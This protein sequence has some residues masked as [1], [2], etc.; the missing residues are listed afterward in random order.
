MDEAVFSDEK[1]DAVTVGD[2]HC[3]R[4]V[5]DSFRREEDVDRLLLKGGISRIM[6][7]LDDMQLWSAFFVLIT[8]LCTSRVPDSKG[9]EF[10][11]CR[12]AF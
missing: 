9:E 10:S 6:I 12:S 11:L 7:N 8:Y 4:K 3:D 5:V 2:L 1:D